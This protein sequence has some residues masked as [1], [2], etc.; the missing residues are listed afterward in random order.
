MKQ[1]M[2][3]YVLERGNRDYGEF[4]RRSDQVEPSLKLNQRKLL[5]Y[6][7][8]PEKSMK[9][10]IAPNRSLNR[11]NPSQPSISELKHAE[12]VTQFNYVS[13]KLHTEMNKY[14]P[15]SFRKNVVLDA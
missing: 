12:I 10:Q 13:E 3:D 6:L 2:V 14:P 15:T 11:E 9:Y 8:N 1:S 7:F 4:Y 5:E